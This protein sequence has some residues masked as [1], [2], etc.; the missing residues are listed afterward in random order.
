MARTKLAAQGFV[1]TTYITAKNDYHRRPASSMNA[2]L[3]PVDG[4]MLR[5][6]IAKVMSARPW[7]A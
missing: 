3:E 5:L 6:G 4:V 7:A 2:L 1:N